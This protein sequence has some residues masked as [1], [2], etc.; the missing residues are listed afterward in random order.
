MYELFSWLAELF[1]PYAK[2]N[3]EVG[4]FQTLINF[5]ELRLRDEKLTPINYQDITDFKVINDKEVMVVFI[6]TIRPGVLIGYHG[7]QINKLTEYMEK[8]YGK[9]V[10]IKL[11]E[12]NTW[13][14]FYYLSSD[15]L[16]DF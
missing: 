15:Y 6:K 12:D 5:F 7:E 9:A 2:K 3:E 8:E 1:S 11:E 13:N 16:Y 14:N 4:V 10:D